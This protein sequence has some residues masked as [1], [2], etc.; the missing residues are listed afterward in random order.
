ALDWQVRSA[1]GAGC[2]GAF[3]F[4]WTDEWYRGGHAIEDWDFGL[5]DR[6]RRP[7]PALAA[8]RA[9]FADVPFPR[10][11]PSP[12]GRPWPRVSVVV[13]SYNGARTIRDCLDG[14]AGLEYPDYEVIV[15]D[16]GSTDAT[17]AIAG[18]Y[19][20]RVIRTENRGLSSARNTG[21]RAA[22]GQL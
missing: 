22:T 16:D 2:A 13:C 6:V 15:V 17:A 9:A 5:T 19:G 3:V 21:W 8:V 20:V 7:K 18:G 4:A 1:F 14:L 11:R 10:S 12:A